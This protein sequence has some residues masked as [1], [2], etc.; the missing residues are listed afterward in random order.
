MEQCSQQLSRTVKKN[1]V[2]ERAQN[3]Q[4]DFWVSKK[5]RKGERKRECIN[6]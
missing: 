1:V 6:E 2:E 5:G 4:M 3:T